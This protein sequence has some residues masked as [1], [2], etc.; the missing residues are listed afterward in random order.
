MIGAELSEEEIACEG[1]VLHE[2]GVE[3]FTRL[4]SGTVGEH[5]I[6]EDV[7]R[8]GVLEVDQDD[9]LLL[10]GSGE[11]GEGGDNGEAAIGAELSALQAAAG[12]D[13]DELA[14][15]AACSAQI[16]VYDCAVGDAGARA[17]GVVGDEVLVLRAEGNDDVTAGCVAERRRRGDGVG[18]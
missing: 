2:D 8:C 3:P 12:V 16:E 13:V 1:A 7:G 15:G 9:R 17:A 6:A 18:V 10:V 4:T 14:R 5:N 11:D